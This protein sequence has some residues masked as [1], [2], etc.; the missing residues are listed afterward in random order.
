MLKKAIVQLAAAFFLVSCAA[1]LAGT[2]SA[3]PTGKGGTIKHALEAEA[4]TPE[5][6]VAKMCQGCHDMQMVTD[7]PKTYDEWTDSVH[8]MI[9]RGAVGTP[10]EV[11]LVMQYLHQ[12]MTA[13]DVNHAS[14]ED[15]HIILDAPDEAVK[16]IIARRKERPFKDIADLKTIAGIDADFVEAKKRMIYFQ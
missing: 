1:G 2:T 14:A 10:A 8:S 6:A 11:A 7:T 13:I 4:K 16:A 9:D 12:N 3:Q 15:L 5:A